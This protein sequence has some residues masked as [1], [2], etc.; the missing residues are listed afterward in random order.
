LRKNPTFSGIP[1]AA[2]ELIFFPRSVLQE[3]HH[4]TTLA[5]LLLLP[6]QHHPQSLLLL[7]AM[8]LEAN[9]SR[10]VQIKVMDSTNTVSKKEMR[11]FPTIVIQLIMQTSDIED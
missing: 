2:P 5:M 8:Q 3:H 4:L 1:L 10:M 11:R 9:T 6:P 7:R